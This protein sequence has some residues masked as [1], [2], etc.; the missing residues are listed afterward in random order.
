MTDPEKFESEAFEENQE[1][2]VPSPVS[3]RI[4]AW[5]GIAYVLIAMLLITYW[6]ATT[7]FVTSITGI[8]IFPLLAAL[9]AQG[10]NNH[11]R[12]KLGEHSG[13]PTL[14]LVTACIM[15][16]LAVLNLIWGITQLM[17]FFGGI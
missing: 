12:A 14:L 2:F 16:I 13:N 17:D 6:I 11:V 7:S 10:I 15:G 8:L 3:K 1:P 4:W 9:C 5:M